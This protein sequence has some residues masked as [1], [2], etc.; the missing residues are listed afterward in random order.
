MKEEFQ[1]RKTI[2]EADGV[3][4]IEDRGDFGLGIAHKDAK[5]Q[6]KIDLNPDL[7]EEVYDDDEDEEEDEEEEESKDYLDMARRKA[8]K[9]KKR[10]A[11]DKQKAVQEF[12]LE[13][14]KQLEESILSHRNEHRERKNEVKR[15]TKCC[16][17]T[18]S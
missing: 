14:G 18:K 12:K 11:I 17:S 16:N 13:D 3:G 10:P 5:P 15:L 2:A 4:E 9:D 1:R 7:K 8:K 6:V